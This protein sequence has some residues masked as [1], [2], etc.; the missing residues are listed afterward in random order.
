MPIASTTDLNAFA[1]ALGVDGLETAK[2]IIGNQDNTNT[3]QGAPV[4]SVSGLTGITY[5][6]GL[7]QQVKITLASMAVTI[8]DTGGVNGAYGSQ[9]IFDCPTGYMLFLGA[10]SNLTFTAAAGIGATGT[11][12]HSIG[13]AAES[14]NDTLDATQANL[15]ASVSSVLAASAGTGKGA[16]TAVLYLDGTSSAVD[17]YLNF[18][19]ADAD[20]TASSSL[21]VSGTITISF[22]NLATS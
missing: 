9:K 19:V 5:I 4:A 18:G 14:T 7:I 22:L 8:T 1:T 10:R 6:Q 17:V 3:T 11:V 20:V 16:S 2:R 12:K 15:I 13:S 21:T